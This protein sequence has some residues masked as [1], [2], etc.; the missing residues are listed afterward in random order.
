MVYNNIPKGQAF[1]LYAISEYTNDTCRP[2]GQSQLDIGI[3]KISKDDGV[4]NNASNIPIFLFRTAW[5]IDLTAD[6]M[7]A[8][9]IV[10][11]SCGYDKTMFV[12][13]SIDT[14]F[15]GTS[16]GGGECTVDDESI[17]SIAKKVKT[18]LIPFLK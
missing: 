10:I 15:T 1:R 11:Y 8:E 2:A 17:E 5:Y 9:K 6:E 3:H 13:R 18:K 16:S 7:N 4:F 14:I 12:Y